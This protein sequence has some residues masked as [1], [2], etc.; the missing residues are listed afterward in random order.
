MTTVKLWGTGKKPVLMQNTLIIKSGLEDA[1]IFATSFNTMNYIKD[2]AVFDQKVDDLNALS[3]YD[4]EQLKTDTEL[5]IERAELIH[6]RYE[7]ATQDYNV[8]ITLLT[9]YKM[10]LISIEKAISNAKCS[11]AVTV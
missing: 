4:L 5:M 6:E 3:L 2:T 10:Y 8:S 1:Q 9:S 7:H 11:D